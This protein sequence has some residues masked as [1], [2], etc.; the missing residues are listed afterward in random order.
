MQRGYAGGLVA[1]TQR[2]GSSLNSH[3]HLHVV[4]TDGVYATDSQG[5]LTFTQAIGIDEHNG[6]EVAAGAAAYATGR[7]APTDGTAHV[8]AGD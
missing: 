5:G 2:F 4:A 6:I 8:A 1:F 3:W 7:S